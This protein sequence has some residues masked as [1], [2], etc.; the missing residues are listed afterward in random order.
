MPIS[1]PQVFFLLGAV[2]GVYVIA[3]VLKF[4]FNRIPH[5]NFKYSMQVRYI[6]SWI[7]SSLLY[8]QSLKIDHADTLTSDSANELAFFTYLIPMLIAALYEA[9]YDKKKALS[10]VIK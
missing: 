5:F 2:V 8:S 1:Q 3:L 7:I 10:K 9:N 4:I 6:L